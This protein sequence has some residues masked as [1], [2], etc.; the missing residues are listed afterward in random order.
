[1][2]TILINHTLAAAQRPKSAAVYNLAFAAAGTTAA[3]AGLFV[4]G[5]TGFYIGVFAAGTLTICGAL[6]YLYRRLGLSLWRQGVSLR[7]EFHQLSLILRTSMA[8][9]VSFVSASALLL[10]M[11]YEVM[12]SE[13]TRARAG[14]CSRRRNGG[15]AGVCPRFTCTGGPE[16]RPAAPASRISEAPAGRTRACHRRA[17]R[18]CKL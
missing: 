4:A 9:Y 13:G 16:T 15:R 12:Q 11:R 2:M 14:S 10:F 3:L 17:I 7:R 8:A 6:V 1:M 18:P 5:I